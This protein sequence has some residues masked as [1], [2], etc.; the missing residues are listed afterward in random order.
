LNN[1]AQTGGNYDDK[2]VNTR[3]DAIFDTHVYAKQHIYARQAKAS[4]SL[5]LNETDQRMT[6]LEPSSLTSLITVSLVVIEAA[7]FLPA[8]I[9]ENAH[10]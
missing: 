9:W 8:F 3:I 2:F 7:A 1:H 4:T 6:N 5:C 10:V